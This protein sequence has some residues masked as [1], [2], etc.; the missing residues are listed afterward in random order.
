MKTYLNSMNV[1]LRNRHIYLPQNDK[2]DTLDTL[3]KKLRATADSEK[4]RQRV[5]LVRDKKQ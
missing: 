3:I 4:G 2:G 5:G 1:P